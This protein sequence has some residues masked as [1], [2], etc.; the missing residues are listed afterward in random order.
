MSRQEK[1]PVYDF[2]FDYFSFRPA[3]L[4]RWSPG[5]NVLLED[6]TPAD[7]GWIEFETVEGGVVLRPESFPAQRR[8]YLAWALE[9]L[10]A[11]RDREPSFACLGLHEW[12]MVYRDPNVRHPYVPLRLSREETDAVVASQPLRCTHFDAFRFFTKEAIPLNRVPLSRA[13]TIDNDQAGCIH[14][15][16]DLYRFAYKIAPFC[17]GD[18]LADAF[19]LATAAREI[20]MRASPY[21]LSGYGFPP[22]Q[23]ETREGREEYV[24]LQRDLHAR[25]VPIRARLLGVYQGLVPGPGTIVPGRSSG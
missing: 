13:T 12:A 16:M 2:L 23:I 3:H 4:M 1:H 11:V 18:L 17:P 24:G 25:S 5:A 20:D 15:T 6:A 7:I 19:E 8:G 22:L 10:E 14:V 9:Y 21:D